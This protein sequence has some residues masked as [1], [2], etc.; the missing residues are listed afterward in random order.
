MEKFVGKNNNI[1]DDDWI[2]LVEQTKQLTISGLKD[3]VHFSKDK[4][5]ESLKETQF[6]IQHDIPGEGLK[7]CPCPKEYGGAAVE[8]NFVNFTNTYTLQLRFEDLSLSDKVK[9]GGT[10]TKESWRKR[11]RVS[12]DRL[13]LL[14]GIK[15]EESY[16]QQ[17][18]DTYMKKEKCFQ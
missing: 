12:A 17:D 3:H 5:Q 8:R 2:S 7:W 14:S 18:Y 13:K 6:W 4:V 10:R 9:K 11:M 16:S 15:T 1:T